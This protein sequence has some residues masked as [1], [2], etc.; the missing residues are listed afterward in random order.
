MVTGIQGQAEQHSKTLSHRRKRK[1][2]PKRFTGVYG[3]CQALPHGRREEST[4]KV[5][6]EIECVREHTKKWK[7]KYN[8]ESIVRER[9]AVVPETRVSEKQLPASGWPVFPQRALAGRLFRVWSWG[10]TIPEAR[11]GNL[12]TPRPFC[13]RN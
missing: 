2:K 9:G 12:C 13:V 5:S 4:G 11:Q 3:P 7:K 6:S 8:L 10:I 1:A